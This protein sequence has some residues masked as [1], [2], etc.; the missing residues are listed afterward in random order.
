MENERI[1][2]SMFKKYNNKFTTRFKIKTAS[3]L[4]DKFLFLVTAL[5]WTV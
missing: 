5:H 4:F 3:Y 2:K 1:R